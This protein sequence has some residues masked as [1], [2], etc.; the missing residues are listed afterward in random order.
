MGFAGIGMRLGLGAT[1]FRL[2]GAGFWL[3][4]AGY[5]LQASG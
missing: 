2:E 1:G 4:A 3:P 5:G